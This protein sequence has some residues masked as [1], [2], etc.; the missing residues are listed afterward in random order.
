ML[1]TTQF[2]GRKYC[3]GYALVTSDGAALFLH[4]EVDA[5]GARLYYSRP[6]KK[7]IESQQWLQLSRDGA[8]EAQACVVD[9]FLRKLAERYQPM[10]ARRGAL[11][12]EL[13]A[14]QHIRH[15]HQLHP[16]ITPDSVETSRVLFGR[17]D[18]PRPPDQKVK[19]VI[20]L[21]SGGIVVEK[22]SVSDSRAEMNLESL[23]QRPI[24]LH[25]Y[26]RF[27]G[28]RIDVDVS[29]RADR[30]AEYVANPPAAFAEL[31][32][33]LAAWDGTSNVG[34]LFHDGYYQAVRAS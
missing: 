8:P 1:C 27:G 33:R 14:L 23:A 20:G 6:G 11:E 25:F 31:R 12:Q 15:L 13:G 26:S 3:P 24:E 9:F 10:L 19:T 29:V 30:I 18:S 4:A 17:F 16:A 21:P 34:R 2:D 7:N 32:Q 28:M 5:N 22:R